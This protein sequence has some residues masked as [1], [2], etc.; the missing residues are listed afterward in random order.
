MYFLIVYMYDLFTL[1]IRNSFAFRT[2]LERVLFD[3]IDPGNVFVFFLDICF[4][5]EISQ[6]PDFPF[7]PPTSLSFS[8]HKPH[9]LI[10][11]LF[12]G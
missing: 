9:K 6:L 8:L 10:L 7:L 3:L 2:V 11:L 4:A 12:I 5:F 1:I